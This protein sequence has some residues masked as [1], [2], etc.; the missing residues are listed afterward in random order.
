[1]SAFGPPVDGLR[2]IRLSLVLIGVGVVVLTVLV[3]VL[4]FF[5]GDRIDQINAERAQNVERNCEDV[6]ARNVAALREL[7]RLLAQRSAGASRE[8][9]RRSRQNTKA[10]IDAMLPL[11][12]C[13][14]LARQQV[15]KNP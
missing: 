12:D 6:N 4:F 3:V 7:D 15:T 9:V 13:E 14:L 11:R 10:L 8:Q 1:M 2:T 5:N